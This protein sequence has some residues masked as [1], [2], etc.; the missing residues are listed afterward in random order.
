MC[1]F[2]KATGYARDMHGDLLKTMVHELNVDIQFLIC[3]TIFNMINYDVYFDA[4]TVKL[5]LLHDW[6]TT[7]MSRVRTSITAFIMVAKRCGMVKDMR[8]AIAQEM[9]A[10]RK[11]P[12]WGYLTFPP[13]VALPGGTKKKRVKTN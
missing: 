11:S 10:A 2:I 4:H 1:K 5:Q 7:W 12:S 8:R 6:Y 3:D 13:G 9:W